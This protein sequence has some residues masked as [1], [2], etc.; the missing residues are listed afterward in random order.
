MDDSGPFLCMLLLLTWLLSV[1]LNMSTTTNR[2]AVDTKVVNTQSNDIS[3]WSGASVVAGG[4]TTVAHNAYF[5]FPWCPHH[6]PVD[7]RDS[8]NSDGC[9]L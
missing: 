9:S 2:S 1:S 6:P 8:L 7:I 3:H 5:T 4:D